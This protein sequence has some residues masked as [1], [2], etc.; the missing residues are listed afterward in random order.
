M[1][2]SLLAMGIFTLVGAITPGPVNVLALRHGAARSRRACAFYVLGASASYAAVVWAMGQSAQWLMQALPRLST[3][4]EWLCAAYL[5]WLAW[6]LA[7]APAEAAEAEEAASGDVSPGESRQHRESPASRT[8]RLLLQG[9]AVQTLNPKAWL[10]ALAGVGLFVLPQADAALALLQF[11][12]MS[13]LAC[14]VG[15]GSWALLGQ[16]LSS[17]LTT[18]RRQRLFHRLLALLLVASVAAMLA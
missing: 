1:S 17:Q 3:T 11:C 12:A 14:L 10:V 15:V 9:A 8:L 18:P 4:A 2:S 6:R 13:L 7:R 16:A 5:L